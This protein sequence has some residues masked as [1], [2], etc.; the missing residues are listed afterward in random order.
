MHPDDRTKRTGEHAEVDR[1][2]TLDTAWG[3]S[4]DETLDELSD[5][6]DETVDREPESN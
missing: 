2:E 4:S 1:L 5:V 6:V 3:D